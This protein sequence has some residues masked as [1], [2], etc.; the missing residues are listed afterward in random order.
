MRRAF[1]ILTLVAACEDNNPSVGHDLSAAASDLSMP[2]SASGCDVVAQDCLD[3]STKCTVVA[4]AT[5]SQPVLAAAC[6]PIA[7]DIAVGASCS[8]TDNLVGHDTCKKGA[9][10]TPLGG[11][12][13]DYRCRALCGDDTDC[14]TGEKCV[15][16]D[17]DDDGVCVKPCTLFASGC[18]ANLDC[19]LVYRDVD[20]QPDAHDLV[21]LCRPFGTALAGDSCNNDLECAARERCDVGHTNLCLA[22][23]DNSNPCVAD[24]GV[25]CQPSGLPN[26]GGTCR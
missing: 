3:P 16:L 6:A 15:S 26:G 10:C 20:D 4:I 8:S 1:V 22:L 14:Q 5:S 17:P 18:G 11:A 25:S 23:C 9:F 21:P 2:M 24:G 13:T 12:A 19:S 7:G